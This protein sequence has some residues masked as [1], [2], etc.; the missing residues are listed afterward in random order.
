[1]DADPSQLEVGMRTGQSIVKAISASGITIYDPIQ[2]QPQLFIP[3]NVLQTLLNKG[4]KGL[5][6]D[7]PLRTRS[8]VL[9][10]KVCSVLGYPIPKRFKK[11]QPRFPGQNFDTYVQKSNNLQIWN[12][13]IAASRRY[14]II[15][16]N[17]KEVVT[18]VRV[19]TGDV[20]A[21]HD[22]TGTL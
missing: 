12:E 21:A 10:S 19:V 11:T 17:E 8:K 18:K 22:T 15:R 7:Q 9:K 3:N 2:D 4:L 14:V 16:V 20:I 13:E 6:L 5:V 1:C